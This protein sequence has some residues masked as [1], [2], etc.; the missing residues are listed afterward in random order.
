FGSLPALSTSFPDTDGSYNQ[1][2]NAP[3]THCSLK[4]LSPL[5]CLVQFNQTQVHFTPQCGSFVQV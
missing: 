3:K 5:P 2:K 1:Q 4:V